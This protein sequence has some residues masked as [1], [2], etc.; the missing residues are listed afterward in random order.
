MGR[1]IFGNVT[2]SYD[3][4]GLD[5]FAIAGS[6]GRPYYSWT[7]TV[8]GSV[9]GDPAG[10][11]EA[12]VTYRW[13]G[14][15]VSCPAGAKFRQ[16]TAATAAPASWAYLDALG[17]PILQVAQSFNVGVS[18]N[19]VADIALMCGFREPLYF[20]KMFKKK[21]GV[22][23]SYYVKTKHAVQDERPDP[24]SV[25]LMLEEDE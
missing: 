11:V 2:R 22:A 20:S 8:P 19:S 18:G 24:D 4:N 16:L 7:E 1:D 9:P 23:P 6:L 10:G 12:T 15:G 5:S 14:S 13:C 25:K 21:Y 3:V 17:R